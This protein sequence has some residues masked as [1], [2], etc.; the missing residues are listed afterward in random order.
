MD[1]LLKS[2]QDS[3]TTLKPKRCFHQVVQT[4]KKKEVCEQT[5]KKN[6]EAES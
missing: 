1:V 2:S 4:K 5:K 3:L 6:T